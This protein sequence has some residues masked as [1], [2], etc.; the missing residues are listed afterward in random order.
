MRI[1]QIYS[2]LDQK[3]KDKLIENY[4]SEIKT[5][6]EIISKYYGVYKNHRMVKNVNKNES[7]VPRNYK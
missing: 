4:I 3:L 6:E 2:L 1:N 5:D 7:T